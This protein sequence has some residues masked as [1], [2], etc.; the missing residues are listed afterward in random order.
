MHETS[1]GIG[2]PSHDAPDSGAR[3]R[4]Q[5]AQQWIG[6]FDDALRQRDCHRAARLFGDDGYWRDILSF[7]WKIATRQGALEIAEALQST[8]EAC[9]AA[10]FRLE[11]QAPMRG[12][13]GGVETLEAFFRFDTR[14][15]HGRGFL[16]LTP[17]PAQPGDWK[18]LNF[19]TT[20]LEL[21][22]FPEDP[23]LTRRR[24]STGRRS[25]DN[26]LDR[27]QA[28]AEF[29][30]KDPEVLI[31]GAGQAGLALGARLAQLD[32]ATLIVDRHER[33][34]D[35]WR[36]RYHSLTLHNE[37][38]TN[39]LPYLPFPK[40]WPVYI[41]KDMLANFMEF[42]AMSMEL[43]V[44]TRTSFLDGT[45]DATARRWTVRVQRADG[46]IRTLRPSQVVMAVGASGVPK[47]PRIRGLEDFGGQVVHSS[48]STDDLE[49]AGKSVLVVGAGTSAHDIAQDLHLRGAEVTMLQRSSTTVVGLEPASVRA[50]AIYRAN[51]GVRPIEE[52]DLMS[53]AIPFDLVRQLHG[54]LSQQM[55]QDDKELLE[56]L[57]SVGFM[58]DNGED[59]TGFFM[60]LLRSLSGYY[61]NVGASDL[62]V[63]RKIKLKT[64]VGIERVKNKE[65][66]FTDGAAMPADMLVMATGYQPLQEAVRTMFGSEVAERVGPIWGIG[67]D[68][69]MRNMW[70]RTRQ[71][72]F[73]V[74]GGT[75]TMC[76]FYSHVTALLIKA[77]LEDLI[78][79]DAGTPE[80][81]Q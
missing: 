8:L 40:T 53:A 22:A 42:Y 9:G 77:A 51:E 5:I 72:G 2:T 73:Y 14:V 50:Y 80:A 37:I 4:R 31:I 7:T 74:A 62:I 60:K 16:R 57:R 55:A 19:L 12:Q 15:A 63:E 49:V 6:G 20:I 11:A 81:R 47:V 3:E 34:G 35:N 61:L 38:C 29:A 45:Y 70:V 67:P 27:R 71:E 17:D 28:A 69:E 25:V 36:K 76:R 58:L 68:G 43:N 48:R 64:G 79:P 78:A 26:W 32:V 41:P 21:K 24:E 23:F 39:H 52:T 54:P 66:L 44:W 33:V 75:L 65:V 13:L 30:E 1:T 46:S 18:A 59:D 10:N 56:G